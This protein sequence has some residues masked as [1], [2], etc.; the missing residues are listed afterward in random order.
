MVGSCKTSS[1]V[2]LAVGASTGTAMT[3]KTTIA[4][5]I[6]NV[7]NSKYRPFK[8]SPL[9]HL[10]QGFAGPLVISSNGCQALGV[11]ISKN[12]WFIRG[13]IFSTAENC[14]VPVL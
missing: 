5:K 3:L 13:G 6:D 9:G 4:P 12:I 10:V 1:G 7:I 8:S 11:F 14:R 2:P